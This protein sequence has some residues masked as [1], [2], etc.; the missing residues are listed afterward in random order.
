MSPAE[1]E[2][3]SFSTELG[4]M[5]MVASKSTIKQLVFGYASAAAAQA[6]LD[7]ALSAGAAAGDEWLWLI[8]RVGEF[9]AGK[10]VDFGDV[11]VDLSHLTGF[12]RR[13]VKHC[14]AIPYG[15]TRSYGE[16]AALAGSPRAARAVGNTMA[17]NRFAIIVPC[18]RVI[19]ADGSLGRYGAPGGSQAKRRMVEMERRGLAAFGPPR[20]RPP[21]RSRALAHV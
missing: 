9:A 3:A 21:G 19:N 12:Q 5:A 7:T 15:Q 13:V 10:C 2:L 16:L 17:S 6:A 20:R 4:W 1:L 11:P 18:H 8:E 14:R